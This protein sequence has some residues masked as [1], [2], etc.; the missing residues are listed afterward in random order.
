M[1]AWCH[2]ALGAGTLA[3]RWVDQARAIDPEYGLAE[4]LDRMLSAGRLPDWAWE[5]PPD[6]AN[7]TAIG[8]GR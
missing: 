1:L 7:G 5:V 6:V 8:T 2:W 3:G 4:L